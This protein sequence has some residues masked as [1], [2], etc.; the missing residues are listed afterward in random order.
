VQFFSPLSKAKDEQQNG[1]IELVDAKDGHR[2]KD[3]FINM[4]AG[5][6]EEV[7]NIHIPIF[8]EIHFL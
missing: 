4:A 2:A 1:N 6:T 3:S 7:K 5:A 8:S